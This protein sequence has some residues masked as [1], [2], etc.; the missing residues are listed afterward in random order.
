MGYELIDTDDLD[1]LPNRSSTALELSDHYVPPGDSVSETATRGP[2]NVGL[3]VYHVAP[4]E[5]LGDGMH[6]HE[7]Q[8]EVFYVVEGTLHVETPEEEYRVQSGQAL[9][10]EPNSPQRAFNPAT[11][12]ESVHLLAIGAP[13]Y[14]VLGKNDS[15]PHT[16]DG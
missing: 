6:Y 16:P 3:R 7:D 11:A 9:V 10:V 14:S 12:A 2:E 8:E 13:S 1:P 4:G 15:H 5:S